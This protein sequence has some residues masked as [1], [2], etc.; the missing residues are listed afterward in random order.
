MK[1]RSDSNARR[2]GVPG[3][4]RFR[5]ADTAAM[6][7]WRWAVAGMAVLAL[8]GGCRRKA[9]QPPPSATQP[10]AQAHLP[11]LDFPEALRTAHPEVAAFLDE[12]LATCLVGDYLGYRRL[13]S[14]MYEPE[15]RE[16]FEAIFHAI[17]SVRV[18]SIDQIDYP[19]VPPPVYRVVSVVELSKE[20]QVKLR[21]THREV[22]ILVFRERGQWRMAPAPASLQPRE[23][24]TASAPATASTPATTTAPSYP[25][26]QDGDY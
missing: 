25:W 21:R 20:R 19:R 4:T 3:V 13:V 24:P 2:R 10:A 23:K 22:A 1:N 5:H 12:F 7:A 17:E 18:E 14:R 6:R 9:E 15:S 11:S 26:D 8:L 16:R